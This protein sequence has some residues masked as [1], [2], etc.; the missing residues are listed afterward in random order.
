MRNAVGSIAVLL[1]L[2]AVASI[3]CAR[4]EVAPADPNKCERAGIPFYMQR[5]YM[6]LKREIPVA[7][8]AGYIAGQVKGDVVHILNA[9][10]EL[11]EFLG[12]DPYVPLASIG[13]DDGLQRERDDLKPPVVS[14]PNKP[15]KPDSNDK[16]T[17]ATESKSAG[18][19]TTATGDVSWDSTVPQALPVSMLYDIVY[20][21]DLDEKYVVSAEGGLG[22]AELGAAMGP[23]STL[24]KFSMS[25]DNTEMGKL[26]A[27]TINKFSDVAVQAATKGLGTGTSGAED[28]VGE[29][30]SAAEAGFREN[31]FI[32]MRYAYVIYATPGLYPI[33][34]NTEYQ[35]ERLEMPRGV[36]Q[37]SRRKA[38]DDFYVLKAR[39]PHTRISFNVRRVL[40]LSTRSDGSQ[41][42]GNGGNNGHASV[43]N[44][45]GGLTFGQVRD[46]AD[47][48]LDKDN[49]SPDATLRNQLTAGV[50]LEGGLKAKL[51]G[52]ITVASDH[53][54]IPIS[55]TS[56]AAS[57]GKV[58]KET[59]RF[60]AA[61]LMGKTNDAKVREALSNEAEKATY[62][63]VSTAR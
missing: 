26:V 47:K 30:T 58:V 16:S 23:G 54:K 51:E 24:N 20:L 22:Q 2:C 29:G 36:P 3:G 18:A 14:D 39:Y 28:G 6:A 12:G 61:F 21:P 37:G 43:A 55:T 34:K 40:R 15:N 32:S 52:A 31:Q 17:E 27:D 62:L 5:P 57:R 33:L 35:N 46:V 7:G 19:L 38:D 56:P 50:S 4:V 48:Y 44:T 53:Y 25:V 1:L 41:P 59:R 49:A 9:P 10:Q 13:L 60:I 8:D 11:L 45:S 42:N 63:K